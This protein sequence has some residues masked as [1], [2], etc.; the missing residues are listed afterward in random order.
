[1]KKK[2]NLFNLFSF[3]SGFFPLR[4]VHGLDDPEQ[5]VRVRRVSGGH[6]FGPEDLL[7]LQEQSGLRVVRQRNRNWRRILPGLDIFTILN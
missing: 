3:L 1:M 2:F 6:V 7:R 4:P 5:P